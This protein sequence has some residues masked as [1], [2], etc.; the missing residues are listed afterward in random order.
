MRVYHF[1]PAEYALADI[2]LRRLK[3]ARLTD[4][5]DPFEFNAINVGGKKEF[6][7][8]LARTKRELNET[9]GLLCFSEK[10]HDPVMWSHYASRHHGICLGFDFANRHA[11]KVSYT[12][13]RVMAQKGDTGDIFLDEDLMASLLFTKYE[14][15]AYE[16]EVRAFVDL[17]YRTVEDGIYYYIFSEDLVLREV[18]LGPLCA[19]PI[20]RV[21]SLVSS[22]EEKIWVMKARLAFKFFR[23]VE[24]ERFKNDRL[25][26]H[27]SHD[28]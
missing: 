10:W 28:G 9:K 12:A 27:L 13:D 22:F 5:N 3:I 7:T 4:V 15:W 8:A 26:K 17:D 25:P 2:A 21:R 14:H 23:V 20:G 1:L 16:E 11:K 24:D 19:L 18:I 6:R